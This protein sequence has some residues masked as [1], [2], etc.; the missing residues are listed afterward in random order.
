MNRR[1]KIAFMGVPT[2]GGNYTHFQYLSKGMMEYDWTLIQ[3][4][5]VNVSLL[6]E[7]AFINVGSHLDRA[8][9][10]IELAQLLFD[11]LINNRYD[12]LIPMN[13]GTAIS[14]ILHLPQSIKIINI[15]N[16][17]TPRVYKAVTEYDKYI[18][19]IICISSKQYNILQKKSTIK[20]KL[21][22]IPHGVS[23]DSKLEKGKNDVFK[24]GFLGRI[25][26]RHKGALLI[27]KILKDIKEPYLL[28]IVGDGEDRDRLLNEL[29]NNK[30]NYHFFGFKTGKEKEEIIS[31]W[32]VMLFP[33]YVEGFGLTLLEVM[34]YGVVPIANE[35]KG[36]TDYVLTDGEDGFI[37]KNNNVR[38]FQKKIEQLISD[39]VLKTEMTSKAVQKVKEKYSLPVILD[40]Y[41]AVFAQAMEYKKPN[42]TEIANWRAYKEY[43]PNYLKRVINKLLI[44]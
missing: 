43:K 10:Q 5:K 18:S 39:P 31:Q 6:E 37:I 38:S 20:N 29:G 23:I 8:K 32:D 17:D 15:V 13:S 2:V 1:L 35:L 26:H 42:T 36:I 30:I 22:L 28:E 3:V 12:I 44:K 25:H 19:K 14:I 27:P 33:S 11:F 21:E 40:Q 34:K 41:R 16:S 9:N 24:I 4:G 7:V